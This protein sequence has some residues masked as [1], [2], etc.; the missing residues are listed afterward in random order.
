M[1]TSGTATFNYN[2]NQIVTAALRKIG[3][4]ASGEVPDAA[5]IQDCSDQL[6]M[7]VKALNATGLHIWTETDATLFL[8]P[9]QISYFLG[10]TTTDHATETYIATNLNATAAIGATSI[11]VL[12]ATGF[13][14]TYNVGIV[15]DSGSIFWSTQTGSASGLTINLTTPLTGTASSGAAVYVYQTNIIR[16]LRVVGGRRYAFSGQLT[17]QMI[18]MARLDY[19]NLPNKQN[20]G[21]IT[22]FFYDPR[23]G[24][25]TQ[26]QMW[27]WPAP[28]DVTS[29]FKFTW[30]RP[31]QDFSAQSNTPDLPQEWLDTLI[32]NLAYKMAPEYD[33]PPERY[34]MLKE[35]AGES[36]QLV[37]G[38]D[39]EPESYLF[40]F[41][42]D[43]MG[44]T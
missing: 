7:L 43:Q 13:G 5:T 20:T 15:M 34:A 10:P 2:L 30:W 16:P 24:A 23:G 17:T 18:Q 22:Q 41:N 12:S 29:V 9:N 38:F 37:M 31:M 6:N 39:R 44:P 28:I 14:D 3:A 33:C 1:T 32:W 21:V 11:T 42:A 27:L 8:Q 35:Q 19:R 25:N 40:G 4:I 36:L 26:G